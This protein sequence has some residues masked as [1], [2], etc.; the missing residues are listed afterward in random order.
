MVSGLSSLSQVVNVWERHPQNGSPLVPQD[1][2]KASPTRMTL[3]TLT[4]DKPIEAMTGIYK[5]CL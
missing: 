2:K 1:S 4:I 5:R 3:E